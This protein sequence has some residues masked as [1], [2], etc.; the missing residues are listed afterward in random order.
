M[1]NG[2]VIGVYMEGS[3]SIIKTLEPGE[4]LDEYIVPLYVYIHPDE[5]ENFYEDPYI[6]ISW[7][8]D[9]RNE[10]KIA[11][12]SIK[13]WKYVFHNNLTAVVPDKV[14]NRL[15]E[16]MN[17][18]VMNTELTYWE[19]I[20]E[21]ITKIYPDKTLD[22]LKEEFNF[23]P[24]SDLGEIPDNVRKYDWE[25]PGNDTGIISDEDFEFYEQDDVMD[26]LTGYMHDNNSN[27]F[28]IYG[29]AQY[30]EE[31][32]LLIIKN[33]YFDFDK[34]EV[35]ENQ[36]KCRLSLSNP[37]YI[38]CDEALTKNEL[39]LITTHIS[40]IWHYIIY[41]CENNNNEFGL[42]TPIPDHIPDYSNL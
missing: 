17:E 33:G 24:I 23:V 7:Q 13:T 11:R 36:I 30:K 21:E 8:C 15:N 42:S 14:I 16:L 2:L 31:F 39:E 35:N 32:Y 38:S 5:V 29:V 18:T 25:D 19:S 9:Y 3:E 34:K 26:P 27:R 41:L 28:E 12:I 37:K 6:K 10:N 1:D 22:M 20:L 40:K 4:S